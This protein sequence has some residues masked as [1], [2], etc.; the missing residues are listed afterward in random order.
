MSDETS[1][2]Q[3]KDALTKKKF[4]QLTLHLKRLD[5][6]IAEIVKWCNSIDATAL[7]DDEPLALRPP[8]RAE[9]PRTEAQA[10]RRADAETQAMRA[11]LK[12]ILDIDSGLKD[13]LVDAEVKKVA[14]ELKAKTEAVGDVLRAAPYEVRVVDVE[15][16]PAGKP[17]MLVRDEIHRCTAVVPCSEANYDGLRTGMRSG[18][19]FAYELDAEELASLVGCWIPIQSEDAADGNPDAGSETDCESPNEDSEDEEQNRPAIGRACD[20]LDKIV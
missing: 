6:T 3:P 7:P 17:M 10:E 13:I 18:E 14:E 1:E 4:I 2:S 8:E 9:P 19:S 15:R 12:G 11:R 20:A 5:A 16:D